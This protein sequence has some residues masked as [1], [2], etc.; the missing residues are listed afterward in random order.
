MK[1]VYPGGGTGVHMPYEFSDIK[2]PAEFELHKQTWEYDE[3]TD[4]YNLIST[5]DVSI[6][7]EPIDIN[8]IAGEKIKAVYPEYKQL[9]IMRTGTDEQVAAMTAFIDAV[10][11]WANGDNPDPWDGTLDAI[12]P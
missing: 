11:A 12:Q 1:L 5:D 8:Y 3:E 9:N 2:T 4:Q 10:R 7:W 6:E